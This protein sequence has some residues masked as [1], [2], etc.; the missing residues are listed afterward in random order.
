MQG[1]SFEADDEEMPLKRSSHRARNCRIM[2]F[3]GMPPS[4]K[5]RSWTRMPFSSS[6][7]LS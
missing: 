6:S 2:S 3:E 4:R 1:P 7:F 5:G